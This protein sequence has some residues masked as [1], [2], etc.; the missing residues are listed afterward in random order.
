MSV[1]VPSK[2]TNC[3]RDP[4]YRL[5][6]TRVLVMCGREDKLWWKGL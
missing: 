2:E 6:T 4:T 5:E 3:G 1:C